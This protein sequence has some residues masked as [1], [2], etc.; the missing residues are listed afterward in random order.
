MD[1]SKERIE[2]GALG[3]CAWMMFWAQLVVLGLVVV[4]GAF[5]AGADRAPGD[6]SCGLILVLAAFALAF[7]QVKNRFDGISAEWGAL[8]VDD[9][10]NLIVVT[11]VFAALGLAGLF[12]AAA[13]G[14]GGLHDSGVALFVASAVAVFLNL[15]HVFDTLDRGH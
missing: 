3:L 7:I 14:Y 11:V 13:A 12:V 9:V 5:F 1:Q 6:A 8:L 15:K 4:L 10:A 2:P